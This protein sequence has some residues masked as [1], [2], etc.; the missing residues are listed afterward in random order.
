MTDSAGGI[1]P[2]VPRIRPELVEGLIRAW[3]RLFRP[4]CV[5]VLSD[6]T[7]TRRCRGSV[8]HA[9]S[10]TGTYGAAESVMVRPLRWAPSQSC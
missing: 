1:D 9:C 8:A 6:G 7:D 10:E 5:I 4:S 3:G 2:G